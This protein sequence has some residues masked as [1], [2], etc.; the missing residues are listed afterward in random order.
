VRPKRGLTGPGRP[1]LRYS[2]VVRASAAASLR[3]RWWNPWCP[4]SSAGPN[5][6]W[7]A[8]TPARIS[9]WIVDSIVLSL[10]MAVA[11]G[12][13]T[14]LVALVNGTGTSSE[15]SGNVL[16]RVAVSASIDASYIG[17]LWSGGRRTLGMVWNGLRVVRATD[18]APIGAGIALVRIA[19][20]E[21]P[22]YLA[23]IISVLVGGSMA[24]EL[25]VVGDLWPWLLLATVSFD[26]R[27]RGL[28]DRA[29]GT[30][31]VVR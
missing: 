2:P 30:A 27:H 7:M 14:R 16:A 28:H 8:S 20:I 10:A 4:T 12:V 5:G 18:G 23:T 25:A 24:A 3:R 15:G 21:A 9:S 17:I 31:V 22:G 13:A 29:A 11:W 19:A 6:T 26:R 1:P